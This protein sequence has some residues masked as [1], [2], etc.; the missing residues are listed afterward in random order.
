MDNKIFYYLYHLLLSQIYSLNSII[1]VIIAF[2]SFSFLAS[3]IYVINDI[4][5]LDNDRAHPYKKK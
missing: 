3:S 2:V 1:S 4:F 5:D